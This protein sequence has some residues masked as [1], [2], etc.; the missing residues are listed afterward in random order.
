MESWETATHLNKFRCWSSHVAQN[1]QKGAQMT[2]DQQ[3][4]AIGTR[5]TVHVSSFFP[6]VQKKGL[7]LEPL[8]AQS[9]RLA[10][11]LSPKH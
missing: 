5:Y 2:E 7:V 4:I 6:L 3:L 9:P 1:L 11:N 8:H 10:L